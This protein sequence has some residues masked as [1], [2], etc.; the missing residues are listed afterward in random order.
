MKCDNKRKRISKLSSIEW[1]SVRN[2]K[3]DKYIIIKEADKSGSVII[4]N[5]THYEKVVYDQLKTIQNLIKKF[6]KQLAT[7]LYV[8]TKK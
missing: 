7:K 5:K 6:M 2:H 3:E 8:F 4:M 1:T